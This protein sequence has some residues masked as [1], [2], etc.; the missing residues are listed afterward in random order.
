MTVH[1]FICDRND[2]EIHPIRLQ[3][4]LCATDMRET[5]IRPDGHI[6]LLPNCN[7][8]LRQICYLWLID[9]CVVAVLGFCG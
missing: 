4:H 2:V 8:E 6:T 9:C 7:F 3:M 1:P 5:D